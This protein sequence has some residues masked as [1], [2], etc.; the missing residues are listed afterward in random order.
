[1]REVTVAA[2]QMKLK[3]SFSKSDVDE[4][5]SHALEMV[6]KAVG[7]GAE[8]IGL[9]EF[10]NVGS[11][12]ENKMPVDVVEPL[13]GPTYQRVVEKAEELKVW[14][15]A[16]SIPAK[17]GDKIYNAGIIVSPDGKVVDFSRAWYY[18]GHYELEGKYPVVETEM[19]RIGC[20]IC[21]DIMIAEIPRMLKF[22][23]AEIIFH[24]TLANE[25][26]LQMFQKF[27]WVRAV[28][29]C[30]FIV[31]INPIAY[32]P[33][34]G[35]L[36]GHSTIFSPLGENIAEAP[37]D[38]EHILVAKLDPNIKAESWFGRRSLTEA[39]KFYDEPLK[40]AI[41]RINYRESLVSALK[42]DSKDI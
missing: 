11:W 41:R 29:N 5:V 2:V 18:P 15:V 42:S 9:P 10:F 16:G 36:P 27:A 32:H 14:L 22:K 40:E 1:M 25:K 12:L 17:K 4:N 30:F 24:P 26:S 37:L 20:I 38:K 19:G 7:M 35:K 33:K 8:I 13:D 39:K 21:G 34:V 23:D 31:Q 3:D 6:E 28:E